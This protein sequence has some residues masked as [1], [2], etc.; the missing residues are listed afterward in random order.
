MSNCIS[1]V[2]RRGGVLDPAHFDYQKLQEMGE[3]RDGDGNVILK[4]G[5][6]WILLMAGL[7][8]HREWIN[9]LWDHVQPAVKIPGVRIDFRCKEESDGMKATC[10]GTVCFQPPGT[11]RPNKPGKDEWDRWWKMWRI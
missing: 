9:F 1:P 3:Y 11:E 4:D 2:G 7:T 10:K 6:D 8:T 5:D